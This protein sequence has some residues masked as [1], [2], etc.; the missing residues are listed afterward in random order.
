MTSSLVGSE[1]CIRDRENP[2]SWNHHEWEEAEEPGEPEEYQDPQEQY[3]Y[4]PEREDDGSWNYY[5]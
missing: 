2:D 5:A 4:D 1:M 3:G